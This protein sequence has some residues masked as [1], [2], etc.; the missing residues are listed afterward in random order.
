MPCGGP[1]RALRARRP[2]RRPC[3]P[4]PTASDCRPGLRLAGRATPLRLSAAGPAAEAEGTPRL[5]TGASSHPAPACKG[6]PGRGRAACG[7][8]HGLRA[9]ARGPGGV[10]RRGLAEAARAPGPAGSLTLAGGGRG[11]PP[12]APTDSEGW[13]WRRVSGRPSSSGP[14]P[15]GGGPAA[16]WARA[17]GT[18]PLGRAGP[19]RREKGRGVRITSLCLHSPF[20]NQ[21]RYSAS[22]LH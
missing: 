11:S 21:G 12:S 5:R 9:R 20:N 10:P 8:L 1:G 14:G 6:G 2:A 22:P 3:P 19:G 15:G 7:G 4:R 18:A 16:P 13:P 17:G